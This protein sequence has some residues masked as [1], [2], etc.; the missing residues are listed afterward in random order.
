MGS[1]ATNMLRTCSSK[2]T[3]V[4]QKNPVKETY[5]A[6]KAT[7]FAIKVRDGLGRY[8]VAKTHRMP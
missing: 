1:G 4:Y 6:I 5:F 2:E 3:Y 7:Y 8:R